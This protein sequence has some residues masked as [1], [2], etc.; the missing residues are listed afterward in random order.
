MK[1]MRQKDQQQMLLD[2]TT[3]KEGEAREAGGRDEL[4][5]AKQQ[6]ESPTGSEKLMEAICE[7]SNLIQ[8]WKRVKEN[9]GSAGIDGMNVDELKDYLDK[10]W[11][12]I[13]QELLTA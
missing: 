4:S 13:R 9:K 11:P 8:A 3:G 7:R 1:R 6:T 2:L 5:I 12:R 10:H